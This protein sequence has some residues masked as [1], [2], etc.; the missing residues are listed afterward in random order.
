MENIEL[1]RGTTSE[2][3]DERGSPVLY[4]HPILGIVKNNIDATRTGK[5]EVFLNHLSA[6][7]QDNPNNWKSVSYLSPFFG[8]TNNAP[9]TSTAGAF[10]GNSHSY[11]FWATPPDIGTEVICIFLNGSPNQGF[12]IGCIPQPGLT[13]M[14]PAIGSSDNIIANAGEASSYGGATRLPVVEINDANQKISDNPSL[15]NQPRPVHSTQAAI[16]FSQGLIRDPER[17][18]IGSSAARESPSRVFGISTPG[19]PIYSGGFTDKTIDAAIKADTPDSKFQITGR[20]GGHSI[21]MDDGDYKGNDQL[22]RFRTS[23]GH[24]IL[25]SDKAETIF[26]IHANGKSYVELGKEGTVDIFSTNSINMRTQGDINLH[27]DNNININAQKNL[28]VK[29]TNIKIESSKNTAMKIGSTFLQDTSGIHTVKAGGAL[30]LSAMGPASLSSSTVTFVTGTMLLL[31]TGTSP[32][33]PK[34]VASIKE[35]AYPDTQF[36]N[37]SGWLPSP[38]KLKSIVSRAPAHSPWVDANKGAVLTVNSAT[39]EGSFSITDGLGAL[40]SVSSIAPDLLASPALLSTVPGLS[41]IAGTAIDSSSLTAMIAQTKSLVDN[42]PIGA[43]IIEGIG[44]VKGY[45][46]ELQ[47]AVG[48]FAQNATQLVRGGVLKPGADSLIDAAVA[49]GIDPKAAF[50][51]SLFTGPLDLS[52]YCG[53]LSAQIGAQTNLIKDAAQGL[54]DNGL[55]KGFESAAQMCGPVFAASI[56]G[57]NPIADLARNL[58]GG[59]GIIGNLTAGL[60]IPSVNSLLGSASQLVGAGNYAS[61]LVNLDPGSGLFSSLS[62]IKDSLPSLIPGIPQ[63]LTGSDAFK[64]LTDAAGSM[65]SKFNIDLPNI[66]AVTDKLNFGG[67]NFLDAAKSIL[68]PDALASFNTAADSLSGNFLKLGTS[69]VGTDLTTDK[70]AAAASTLLGDAKIPPI[71]SNASEYV[72]SAVSSVTNTVNGVTTTVTADLNIAQS[73]AV[74]IRSQIDNLTSTVGPDA[75]GLR[76]LTSKY[77]SAVQQIE[78]YN[79]S[80]TTTTTTT[81]GGKVT[82]RSAT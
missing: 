10:N 56:A 30:S 7:D 64:T 59:S 81:T 32:I 82:I 35:N 67:Q 9:N 73:T 75:P 49:A 40:A 39:D 61:S 47:A 22:M 63:S 20:Q 60:N 79:N 46:G 33:K 15:A 36:D 54:T 62:S 57:V 41:G 4:S 37:T 72:Q 45:T 2:N 74:T 38:G 12:Y 28:T 80:T 19:R 1:T 76:D 78:S 13:H 53:D 21:V 70:I 27:A 77:K 44:V 14:V 42:S 68:P 48:D 52:S 50:S 58:T 69:A 25:M 6:T 71:F 11:G 29:A 3:T 5:I 8:Y 55:L 66:T 16:L 18:T 43:A 23:T 65:A 24:Q 34:S 26:V 51:S 31:N 17:G